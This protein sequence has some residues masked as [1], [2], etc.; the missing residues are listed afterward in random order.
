MKLAREETS[1]M[2]KSSPCEFLCDH[3]A[4]ALCG[5]SL[6]TKAVRPCVL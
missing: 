4:A 6:G 2:G 5:A 1:L 3:S